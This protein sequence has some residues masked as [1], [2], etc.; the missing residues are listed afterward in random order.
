MA[1]D[2]KIFCSDGLISKTTPSSLP[3]NFFG[4]VKN[5]FKG[6]KE[7]WDE[8]NRP[9]TE[10]EQKEWAKFIADNP[11]YDARNPMGFYFHDPFSSF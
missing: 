5:F 8:M 4:K 11:Y 2:D 3:E 10:E 7:L 9:Q 1:K 6:L